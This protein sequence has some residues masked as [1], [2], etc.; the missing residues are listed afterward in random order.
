[1]KILK[2]ICVLAVLSLSFSASFAQ[3]KAEESGDASEDSIQ[4]TFSYGPGGP[5]RSDREFYAGD[6]ICGFG[7][8]SNEF[9]FDNK[10]S[11][12][13]RVFLEGVTYLLP[14]TGDTYGEVT[15]NQKTIT[16][17]FSLTT[18]NSLKAGEYQLCFEMHDRLND[19]THVKKETIKILDGTEFGLRFLSAWY[20]YRHTPPETWIPSSSCF[21]LGEIMQ[22]RF[23]IGGL[24]VSDKKTVDA[25]TEL[26]LIDENDETINLLGDTPQAYLRQQ[27]YVDDPYRT[28]PFTHA[29]ILTKPGEYRLKIKVSDLNSDKKDTYIFPI[30]VLKSAGAVIHEREDKTEN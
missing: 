2:K 25:F 10:Y 28:F 30:K 16:N 6:T 29:F 18:P 7:E 20:G 12:D 3:D 14:V 9:V 27:I 13:V 11:A 21:G 1:M 24:T 17:A 8:F 15:N 23:T 4:V 22:I 5:L 19:K 26:Y